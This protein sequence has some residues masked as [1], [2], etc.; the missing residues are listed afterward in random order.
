MES[1]PQSAMI[2]IW[3]VILNVSR[4]LIK[5]VIYASLTQTQKARWARI[6]GYQIFL[7]NLICKN[8]ILNAKPKPENRLIFGICLHSYKMQKKALS[9]NSN[10][11]KLKLFWSFSVCIRLIDG[12]V[13][14]F[15]FIHRPNIHKVSTTLIS[16]SGGPLIYSSFGPGHD[17]CFGLYQKH[18]PA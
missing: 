10:L 8:Q 6:T 2:D 13:K 4:K 1:I 3:C 16:S 11:V 18:L 14:L 5:I 17:Q 7:S 12:F 15:H 9:Q